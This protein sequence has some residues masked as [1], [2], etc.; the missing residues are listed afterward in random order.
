M[1]KACNAH[2]RKTIASL[3][4]SP[5]PQDLSGDNLLSPDPDRLPP[6]AA[7]L[8]QNWRRFL[9]RV[10]WPSI[11]N[12]LRHRIS[13]SKGDELLLATVEVRQIAATVP[14][15]GLAIRDRLF[16]FLFHALVRMKGRADMG[17]DVATGTQSLACGSSAGGTPASQRY[18]PTAH[19]I[20][21]TLRASRVRAC[22]ASGLRG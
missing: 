3:A 7:R 9:S 20:S 17:S 16:V 1:P 12:C 21:A 15:R 13:Q 18:G 11:Q 14:T 22:A 5:R 8:N 2:R 10:L 19:F 6:D 4:Q